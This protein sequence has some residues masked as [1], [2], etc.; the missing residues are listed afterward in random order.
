MPLAKV[1]QQTLLG[2]VEAEET[3]RLVGVKVATASK[4][5]A[6]P[7]AICIKSARDS[8]DATKPHE[9]RMENVR[10]WV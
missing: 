4:K 3:L 6:T 8:S 9:R 1:G 5:E 2:Q 7:V 10:W